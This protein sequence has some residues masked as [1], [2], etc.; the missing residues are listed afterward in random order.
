VALAGCATKALQDDSARMASLED[1]HDR[2]HE[3]LEK[4]AAKEPLVASARRPWAG[5]ARDPL[6]LIEELAGNVAWRYLDRVTVDLSEVEATARELRKKDLPRPRQGRRMEYERRPGKSDGP[7]RAGSRASSARPRPDRRRAAGGRPG[8][9]GDATLRFGWDSAGLANVVCKDFEL[10]REIRGRV[11]AQRHLV[12]ARCAS[13]TPGEPDRDARLSCP[14]DP[15]LDLTARS[16]LSL[17]R[18]VPDTSGSG[19]RWI[20][21]RLSGA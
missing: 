6:G 4:A 17:M 1:A 3:R 20:P 9:G 8:D 18:L 16:W 12:S 5:G 11:L 19:T 15:P 10:T 21:T 2:L 14:E 7:P 13:T